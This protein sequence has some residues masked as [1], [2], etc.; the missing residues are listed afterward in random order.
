MSENLIAMI[1]KIFR[2]RLRR[3]YP[4]MKVGGQRIECHDRRLNVRRD[5][6]RPIIGKRYP[7]GI[8]ERIKMH[9]Q[10]QSVGRIQALGIGNRRITPGLGVR[11]PQERRL[12]Y[13]R[14][15]TG[16]APKVQLFDLI[17]V[18]PEASTN[19]ALA[20]RSLGQYRARVRRQSCRSPE[21]F[22]QQYSVIRQVLLTVTNHETI[23]C[24]ILRKYKPG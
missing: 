13:A 2:L 10:G 18:L 9:D 6:H 20:L 16:T 11:S 22:A 8:E 12:R 5:K 17:L 3:N 23:R 15:R 4:Q 14:Y 7:P 21:D 19:N 1:R 24:R